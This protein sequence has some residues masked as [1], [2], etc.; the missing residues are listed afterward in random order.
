[1]SLQKHL[2]GKNSVRQNH[3]TLLDLSELVRAPMCSCIFALF[4]GRMGMGRELRPVPLQEV[5][6]HFAEELWEL[7]IYQGR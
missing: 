7:S 2:W 6:I 4:F 5:N 3:G 1:M